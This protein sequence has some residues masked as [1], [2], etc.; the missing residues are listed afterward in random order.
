MPRNA[1]EFSDRSLHFSRKRV[2]FLDFAVN[3][4]KF[5][6]LNS[7][8][9]ALPDAK[10]VK[11]H[12]FCSDFSPS[13]VNFDKTAQTRFLQ[14]R[15]YEGRFC[16][17]KM[18]KAPKRLPKPPTFP[19]AQETPPRKPPLVHISDPKWRQTSFWP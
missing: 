16:S 5:F 18:P 4:R 7:P 19:S 10:I 3:V 1:A 12:T 11:T 9:H 17:S 8:F 2:I 6:F 13:P 15:K 14:L